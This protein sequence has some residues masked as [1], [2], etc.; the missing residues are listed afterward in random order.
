MDRLFRSYLKAVDLGWVLEEELFKNAPVIS[1]EGREAL[2]DLI[3]NS[4]MESG[5]QQQ[6]DVLEQLAM[7]LGN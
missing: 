5:M 7:S 3:L 6:M 4:G 2:R 1:P